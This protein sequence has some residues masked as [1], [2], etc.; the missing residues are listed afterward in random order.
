MNLSYS[1]CSDQTDSHHERFSLF[2]CKRTGLA[3]S[4]LAP[5]TRR[6][7][8]SKNDFEG[9]TPIF[10]AYRGYSILDYALDHVLEDALVADVRAFL[11][12]PVEISSSCVGRSS[13]GDLHL[14][15]LLV[16]QLNFALGPAN[17]T[18][19][20]ASKR[21]VPLCRVPGTFHGTNLAVSKGDGANA[22]I[23]DGQIRIREITD[24]PVDRSG[25]AAKKP[26]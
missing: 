24:F 14:R 18:M 1:S 12:H 19:I 21:T 17:G 8:A 23:L 11:S 7:I 26:A 13:R 25:L 22:I 5:L 9:G 6:A 2:R 10:T 20:R 15:A 16:V 4:N 3:D